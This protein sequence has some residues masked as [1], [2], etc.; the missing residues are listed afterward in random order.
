MPRKLKAIIKVLLPNYPNPF[1]NSTVI[2]YRTIEP[3]N[4]RLI[5]YDGLGKTIRVL[6]NEY[7]A[8]GEHKISWD[9]KDDSENSVASGIYI[10]R[11]DSGNRSESRQMIMIK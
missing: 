6:L 8:A 9:G 5:I 4:V 2:N 11:L 10:Y 3:G 7:E 1:N